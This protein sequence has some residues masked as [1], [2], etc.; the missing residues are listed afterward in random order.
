MKII[1]DIQITL[2][3]FFKPIFQHKQKYTY[4]NYIIT[5]CSQKL[6]GVGIYIFA[7]ELIIENKWLGKD[8]L[9]QHH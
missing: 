5:V 8:E 3:F 2:L 9:D 7:G 1:Q 6:G 4:T